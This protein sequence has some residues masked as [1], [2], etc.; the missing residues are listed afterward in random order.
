M[1]LSRAF[2]IDGEAFLSRERMHDELALKLGLPGWYGRNLDA[3]LDC[4]SSI[5]DPS[6]NLCDRWEVQPGRSLV[7]RLQE[8]SAAL[9]TEL[10]RD[11]AQVISDANH[12]LS[13]GSTGTRIWIE[14][15]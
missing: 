14:L 12:R 9:S 7:L 13:E 8:A 11:F 6:S 4:L 10:F 3:L 1:I 5:D 2:V 15:R